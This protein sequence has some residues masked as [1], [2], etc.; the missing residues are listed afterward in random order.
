MGTKGFFA[1]VAEKFGGDK[2]DRTADLLHA[3]QALSQLSYTPD[4]KKANYTE[5]PGPSQCKAVAM[6]RASQM[7]LRIPV[8]SESVPIRSSLCPISRFLYTFQGCRNDMTGRTDIHA[9]ET[10]ADLAEQG[11]GTHAYMGLMHEEMFELGI[12]CYL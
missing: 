11:A 8:V 9:H 7:N 6:S 5:A 10:A 1:A 4:K 3:M 12:S 2:R